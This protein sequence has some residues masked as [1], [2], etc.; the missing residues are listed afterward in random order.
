M[1]SSSRICLAITAL[2][3]AASNVWAVPAADSAP[4]PSDV[5]PPAG[6]IWQRQAALSR[7]DGRDQGFLGDMGMALPPSGLSSSSRWLGPLLLIATTLS[8][9]DDDGEIQKWIQSSRDKRLDRFATIGETFGDGRYAFPTLGLLYCLGRVSG[10]TRSIQTARLGFESVVVSGA[11]VGALK[12][13][14]HK[15]RPSER[16]S[17]DTA[18]SGP[19]LSGLHLSFP[20]GHSACAFAV[21]TV[22]ADEF[23]DNRFVPPLAYGAA[24]LCAFSRVR[25]NAHYLSDVIVGSAIGYFTARVV[26]TRHGVT[27]ASHLSVE[28]H[29][30][31]RAPGLAISYVF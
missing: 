20:S 13:L 28:P 29:M 9:A 3:L 11:V 25:T 1:R 17:E 23:G 14:S 24:A 27:R 10:D 18:W 12:Y 4:S 19:S 5:K 6:T 31:G 8:L 21:G 2:A 26:L 30:C 15:H 16:G 22:I 7:H